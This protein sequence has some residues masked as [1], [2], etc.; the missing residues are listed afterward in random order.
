MDPI[1]EITA[2]WLECF[3]DSKARG[4]NLADSIFWRLALH[5]LPEAVDGGD[6]R[7]QAVLAEIRAAVEQRT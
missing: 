7:V 6:P 4:E 3:N 1:S 2:D 5:G